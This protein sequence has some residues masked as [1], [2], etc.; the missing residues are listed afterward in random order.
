[1]LILPEK[2]P[3]FFFFCVDLSIVINHKTRGGRSV[4]G[5]VCPQLLTNITQPHKT[6]GHVPWVT[7]LSVTLSLRVL[8]HSSLWVSHRKFASSTRVAATAS[9]S[10]SVG[11]RA[12]V[13]RMVPKSKVPQLYRMTFRTPDLVSV[14]CRTATPVNYVRTLP[15]SVKFIIPVRQ[16]HYFH[17]WSTWWNRELGT[18]LPIETKIMDLTWQTQHKLCGHRH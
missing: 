17:Q 14:L 18:K 11:C 10:S 6:E 16:V 2:L 3:E 13:R 9:T 8:T 7:W 12:T 5:P 1:M 15:L 4:V